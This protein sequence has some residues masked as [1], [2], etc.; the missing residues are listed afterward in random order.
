MRRIGRRPTET[1]CQS[2][3]CNLF[4]KVEKSL[5]SL[6]FM[7]RP[8]RQLTPEADALWAE[9]LARYDAGHVTIDDLVQEIGFSERTIYYRLREARER[10]EMYGPGIVGD[11]AGA[12]GDGSVAP[13][14]AGPEIDEA[15][16]LVLT[17]DP[18]REIRPVHHYTD[19]TVEGE[20]VGEVMYQ[21]HHY[22]DLTTD[23]TSLDA[24]G[25]AVLVGA[26]NGATAIGGHGGNRLPAPRLEGQRLRRNRLGT[27]DKTEPGGPTKPKPNPKGLQG[28]LG[29]GTKKAAKVR[30]KTG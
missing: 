30:R 9:A 12:S 15:P 11:D 3:H 23:R 6:P 22:Y 16:F 2:G 25:G 13:E 18:L 27:G 10:R 7:P 28:G 29:G 1:P 8:L 20:A 24:V 19:G 17:T 21:Q 26:R 4:F 14:R 5:L